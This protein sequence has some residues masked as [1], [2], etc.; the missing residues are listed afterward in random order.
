M[1]ELETV[2]EIGNMLAKAPPPI[3]IIGSIISI[4]FESAA[5]LAESGRDP[6]EEIRR[7]HKADPLVRKVHKEW[8]DA[9]DDKWPP[10]L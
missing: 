3:N 8:Q 6:V 2:A 9:L 7:I 4:V 5:A 10:T 1:R